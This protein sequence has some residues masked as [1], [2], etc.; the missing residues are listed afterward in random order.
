[1]RPQKKIFLFVLYVI[2]VL[3]VY[4]T[5]S[6]LARY[7]TT[8]RVDSDF[9]IGDVLYFDYTRGSLFRGDDLIIGVPNDEEVKDAEGNVISVINRIET[10]NFTPGDKLRYF[11]YVANVNEDG[12]EYNSLDG[13]LHITA[14]AVLSMPYYQADYRF[15][16][17]VTYREIPNSG[18]AGAFTDLTSDRNLDLP[19]YEQNNPKPKKYEFEVFV[20]LDDQV[21]DT[22]DDDYVDATLSIYLY[23][24]AA[25]KN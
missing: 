5:S 13:L 3:V 6:T 25:N 17:T 16:C 18:E 23:I 15:N 19:V 21:Q 8:D 7:V 12:T 14:T 22:S 4:L 20:L 9:T 24:D 10:K 11:F 1:M 2:L